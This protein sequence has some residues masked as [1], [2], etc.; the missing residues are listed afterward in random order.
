MTTE[1]VLSEIKMMAKNFWTVPDCMGNYSLKINRN[2]TTTK[3]QRMKTC[4]VRTNI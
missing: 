3:M 1:L 2:Y 4:R